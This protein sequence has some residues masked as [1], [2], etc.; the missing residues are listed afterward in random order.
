MNKAVFMAADNKFFFTKEVF[1]MF[2]HPFSQF[3]YNLAV[4]ASNDSL[5]ILDNFLFKS[6]KYS[7][8]QLI[9][10]IKLFSNFYILKFSNSGFENTSYLRSIFSIENHSDN[11][12]ST[13]FWWKNINWISDVKYILTKEDLFDELVVNST[14]VNVFK[15]SFSNL[16]PYFYFPLTL[17][18]DS[19]GGNLI[20]V[21]P[22]IVPVSQ[23]YSTIE[24]DL[25]S[26]WEKI[27]EENFIAKLEYTLSYKY[28]FSTTSDMGYAHEIFKSLDLSIRNDI[29][30]GKSLCIEKKHLP[31]IIFTIFNEGVLIN[32]FKKPLLN[33]FILLTSGAT[34]T[35][36]HK[37]LKLRSYQF[38]MIFL[39]VTVLLSYL[40]LGLQFLEYCS[41][42]FSINDG[43]YGSIF[44]VLTGFH[45]LHVLIGSVFLSASFY[46]F[47][48]QHFTPAVHLGFEFAIWYWHFVDVVWLFLYFTLYLWPNSYFFGFSHVSIFPRSMSFAAQIN[49]NSICDFNEIF[50]YHVSKF[51]WDTTRNI[52]E[53]LL[54]NPYIGVRFIEDLATMYYRYPRPTSLWTEVMFN[55]K[56]ISPVNNIFPTEKIDFKDFIQ[57]L[58]I[59]RN[60]Y[61]WLVSGVGK[62][63]I[64]NTLPPS[65]GKF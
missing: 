46:R 44:F 60:C 22:Y 42:G 21:N 8:D 52:I 9:Y 14:V 24:A 13:F 11:E 39:Q 1:D 56:K 35:V 41:A 18:V 26:A 10:T 12:Y 25:Q 27:V 3:N 23:L 16:A 20:A 47:S 65:T 49:L 7:F 62:P 28:L 54:D 58:G 59:P 5:N 51:D 48:Q 15:T 45:G 17:I 31:S 29:E 30:L 4:N 2:A 40:F 55:T 43:V 36:S 57:T 6:K 53:E 64:S 34:I 33:T 38:S 61:N 37:L 19:N 63:P 50:K 32:P